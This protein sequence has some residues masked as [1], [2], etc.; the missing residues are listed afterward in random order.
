[1]AAKSFFSLLTCF[2]ISF[3]AGRRK[4]K[5]ITVNAYLFSVLLSPNML[6]GLFGEGF[7]AVWGVFGGILKAFGGILEAC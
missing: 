3:P 2:L 4:P 5:N 6:L 7:E 1:M